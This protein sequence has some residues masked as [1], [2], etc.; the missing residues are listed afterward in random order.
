AAAAG[1]ARQ[2]LTALEECVEQGRDAGSFASDLE[3]RSREL[4]LVQILGE[5]PTELSLTPEADAALEAVRAGADARTRLE[6]A[7]VKAARPDVDSS[8]RALL[9]RIE[10]LERGGT[11]AAA[12]GTHGGQPG[13]A[14]GNPVHTSP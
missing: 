4:L 1:D 8:M 5:V 7:L 6:L 12:P 10:R 11:P 13:P 9:A 14:A 2:A 3:V